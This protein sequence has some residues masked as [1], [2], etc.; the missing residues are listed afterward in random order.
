[1]ETIGIQTSAMLVELNISS[2]TARKLD[3]RVSDEVDA[4][5]ATRARA[6]N[7][8]KNL[9]AGTQVLDSI[10][11]YAAN[12]RAWHN[13]QTIPWSDNGLRLLPMPLFL[14]YKAQLNTLESNYNKLVDNFIE[15]YPNL[16]SAAAFNLGDLFD[17]DEYPEAEKVRTKFG[18]NYYFTPVPMAGDFRVDT[19]EAA[20]AELKQHYEQQYNS[21]LEKAMRDVWQRMHDCLTHM[22]DRLTDEVVDGDIK[23]KIFRDS[24]I[25]NAMELIDMMPALNLTNDPKLTQASNDLRKALVGM[26][27]K[28]LRDNKT[29]RESV[30]MDVEEILSKFSF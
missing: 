28:E 26:D 6:G 19:N 30:R 21:R 8:N 12:A 7:Y 15:A 14:D 11:K 10:I 25:E 16:V 3:R 5:K 2:W 13:K 20:L 18:F 9:L 23:K 27:V 24:L 1:M 22:K 17:R 29:A 4:T